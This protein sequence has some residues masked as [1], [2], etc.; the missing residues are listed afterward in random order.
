MKTKS[1]GNILFLILIAVALFA[2]LSYAI[3]QSGRIGGNGLSREQAK[4]KATELLQYA[5][6]I[7]QTMLRLTH[8]NGC[9]YKAIDY[10][11]AFGDPDDYG[12]PCNIF[13]YTEGGGVDY[14]RYPDE[15]SDIYNQTNTSPSWPGRR[16]SFINQ[17]NV[18]GLGTEAGKEM[19]LYFFHIVPNLCE[20]INDI[21]GIAEEPAPEE[22][23]CHGCAWEN[24]MYS[25]ELTDNLFTFG[26]QA[27]NIAGH[28][29]GCYTSVDDDN[30]H[31]F[32]YVLNEQ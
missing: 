9:D 3:T 20:A 26:D 1:N 16:M 15:T 11:D 31:H 30:N 10:D 6:L 13:D 23:A 29:F 22:T 27:T 17:H 28:S 32:Y 14:M 8:T 7:Q 25:G 24:P 21:A 4:L 19:M 2:A 12:G 5:S 18:A